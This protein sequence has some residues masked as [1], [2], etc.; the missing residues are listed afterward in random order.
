[1]NGDPAGLESTDPSSESDPRRERSGSR[2][3]AFWEETA[4][5]FHVLGALAEEIGEW[6]LAREAEDAAARA[7]GE[8]QRCS[9]GVHGE[10]PPQAEMKL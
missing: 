10:D 1:M 6:K 4:Q 7:I 3:K 2:D 5:A 8:G 9:Q